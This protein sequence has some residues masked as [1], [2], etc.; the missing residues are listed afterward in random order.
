MLTSCVLRSVLKRISCTAA[1]PT[2]VPAAPLDP[3]ELDAI[4]A[5]A[6]R[7]DAEVMEEYYLH[8]A[9]HKDTL[10]LEPIYARYASLTSLETAQRVGASVDGNRGIREL[11]R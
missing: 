8:Y 3:R 11:W 6:D 7:F 9:G 4:R 1:Y 5:D 2:D 10:E